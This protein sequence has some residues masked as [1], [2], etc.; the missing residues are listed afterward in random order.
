MALAFLVEE[1]RMNSCG[2]QPINTLRL[3][4]NGRHL[5]DAIFKWI[6]LNENVWIL[7][8]ISL[9]FAPKCLINNIPALVQIM[10]WCRL[11]NKPL[12]GPVMVRLLTHICI[13]W[14]E[15][16]WVI[17]TVLFMVKADTII[18][19]MQADLVG[20]IHWSSHLTWPT[21]SHQTGTKLTH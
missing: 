6:F 18:Q 1:A 21:I 19:P 14:F 11:G 9:K 4:Q 8:K 7:I 17:L 10:A 16:I 15:S 12:S 13:T 3:R 2:N 20:I 5:S